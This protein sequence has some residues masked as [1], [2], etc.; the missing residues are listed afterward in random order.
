MRSISL[1]LKQFSKS[2]ILLAG[3][4]VLGFTA[5]AQ[6]DAAKGEAL[7]TTKCT[8]CHAIDRK[9][10]GPALGPIIKSSTDDAWLTKWVQNNTALIAAKDPKAVAIYT[11]FG[12]AAMTQFAKPKPVVAGATATA[13]DSGP[14]DLV[15]YGLIA[16][17]VIA[18]I[19]I[20]V[21]N[22]VI[23]TL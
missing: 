15:I 12:Q 6:G 17:I 19:I 3:F 8:A 13:A 14:S 16:V 10:V 4:A 9:V 20:L 18:F 11:E 5:R 23:A 1:I 7:F 21:L 2:V 22:K